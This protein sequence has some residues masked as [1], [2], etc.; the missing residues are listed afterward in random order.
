M[1][2]DFRKVIARTYGAGL[3]LPIFLDTRLRIYRGTEVENVDVLPLGLIIGLIVM[4][5]IILR[6]KAIPRAG[7]VASVLVVPPTAM[8]L[9]TR[10]AGTA[11]GVELFALYF[12]PLVIGMTVGGAI[13]A[14]GHMDK[15]LSSFATTLAII[16]GAH[17]VYSVA[18]MG[19]TGA[20]I[21]RGTFDLLGLF[22][23]YQKFVY[24]PTSLALAFGVVLFHAGYSTWRRGAMGAFII[25]TLVMMAAREPFVMI[26]LLC[27]LAVL[28]NPSVKNIVRGGVVVLLVGL[29]AIFLA[30]HASDARVVL[31]FA[32]MVNAETTADLTGHR[33]VIAG[34]H[35]ENLRGGT[36]LLGEA[37]DQSGAFRRT[38]HNQYLELL[39]RGGVVFAAVVIF[40]LA[41]TIG[42][43]RAAWVHG[44]G[45]EWKFVMCAVA[46]IMVVSFN[47]NVALRAPYASLVI[48]TLVGAGVGAARLPLTRR[49]LLS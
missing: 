42:A 37:F 22:S 32:S 27:V 24:Y 5:L 10:G 49:A 1:A 20:L 11:E 25:M 19:F 40:A 38:P 15:A 3:G 14:W 6:A 43:A 39:L 46:V 18:T 41:L 47:V 45:W 26:A 28:L 35:L 13:A 2:C 31:K 16:G 23:I 30:Q 29:I 44:E 48:W 21:G 4:A 36:W 33:D 9:V 17:V 12:V 7:V 8:F 34:R